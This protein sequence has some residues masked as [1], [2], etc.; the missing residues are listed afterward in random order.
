MLDFSREQPVHMCVFIVTLDFCAHDGLQPNVQTDYTEENRVRSKV[1]FCMWGMSSWKNC[2]TP[3]ARALH[4]KGKIKSKDVLLFVWISCASAF[5]NRSTKAVIQ[6]TS[7]SAVKTA[8]ANSCLD[9][10]DSA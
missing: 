1:P 2:F 10:I 6:S 5:T 8:S 7:C 3:C 4:K 9:P